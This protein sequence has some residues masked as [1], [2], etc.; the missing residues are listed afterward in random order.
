MNERERRRARVPAAHLAVADHTSQR[1]RGGAIAD[2]SAQATAVEAL[3][4]VHP[5]CSS[6]LVPRSLR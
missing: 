6:A 5:S 4:D 1:L 2:G 3:V